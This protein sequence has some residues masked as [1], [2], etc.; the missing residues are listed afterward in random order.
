MDM[1]PGAQDVLRAG[2]TL[3]MPIMLFGE[4]GHIIGCS[5]HLLVTEGGAKSLTSTPRT[6][7]RVDGE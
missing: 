6:L 1:V 7:Y 4:K 2:M 3:H 5:D